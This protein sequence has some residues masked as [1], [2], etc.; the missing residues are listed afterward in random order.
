[1]DHWRKL[2][3]S[4]AWFWLFAPAV[5]AMAGL[6]YS[7]IF[8]VEALSA[9]MR[10]AFIAAPILLYERGNMLIRWRDIV[11][12]AATPVFVLATIATY[13]LMILIGNAA[14]GT[15]LHHLFGHM[16]TAREAMALSESGLAYAL[17]AS[18]LITFIFRVRDLIGPSLFTSLLLGRYHRPTEEERIFLFLDV[19]GSTHFAD[20][21]G[22]LE[23]QAYLGQIFSALS[24]PVRRSRGSIDDYIGDMALVTW[25]L[26]RGV[27]EA[28]CLRCVFDF[29]ALLQQQ[30]PTWQARFGQV[31][32]FRAVLHCGSVVTAEI[33]LERH[34]IAYFGDV[35]NTTGRLECLSKSLN[36]RVLVSADLLSAVRALPGHLEAA[37][38]GFHA[39]RGRAEPLEVSAI[40]LRSDQLT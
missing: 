16:R 28:A 24:L 17:S 37:N 22:D 1:M 31:P 15:V 6:V 11:R 19:A 2:L 4:R 27:R 40:R 25:P 7:Q 10:G 14:A 8:N 20:R 26:H 5:G 39:M 36:E 32:E 23:T 12:K 21:Y 29:A 30:A 9:A 35:V 38:L 13:I 18:A 3:N 34:K 33:G